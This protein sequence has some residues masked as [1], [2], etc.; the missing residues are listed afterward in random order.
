[1]PTV[2][3][4]LSGLTWPARVVQASCT[5]DHAVR[6]VLL[7]SHRAHGRRPSATLHS[8]QDSLCVQAVDVVPLGEP[9]SF[10]PLHGAA[11]DGVF[12]L[13]YKQSSH[14]WRNSSMPR[15]F[16]IRNSTSISKV[17]SN[18]LTPS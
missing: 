8:F 12:D 18:Q 10:S 7:P 1:M 2:A 4:V 13:L 11:R 5:A 17:P 14:I 9:T 15:N 3:E 16:T 6:R